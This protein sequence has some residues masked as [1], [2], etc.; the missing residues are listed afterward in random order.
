MDNKRV[1][2]IR[3][4]FKKHP[5]LSLI[6]ADLVDVEDGNVTLELTKKKELTQMF[7]Y[8]HGGVLASICDSACCNAAATTLSSGWH[9]VTVD[10]NISYFR[11]ANSKGIKAYAKV[12]KTG[13]NLVFCEAEIFD[14]EDNKLLCKGIV[15]VKPVE[16]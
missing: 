5:F 16:I 12:L 15:T 1:E 2:E 8:I 14:I 9:V 11:P 10:L 3:Q 6:G 4:N 7:G 13:K